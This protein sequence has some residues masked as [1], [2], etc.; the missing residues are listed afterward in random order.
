MLH[1][2]RVMEALSPENIRTH[3]V[4]GQN[5][6]GS[7]GISTSSIQEFDPVTMTAKTCSGKTY[8]LVGQPD[9]S[10]LGKAAWRKWCTD[11]SIVEERDVTR[12]YYKN[13]A[14]ETTVTFKRLN[15]RGV[16]AGN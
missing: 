13:T 4:C 10:P 15:R 11:N 2:W 16:T 8:F 5:P 1:R 12:D 14:Q 7:F 9:T 3:H 6:S